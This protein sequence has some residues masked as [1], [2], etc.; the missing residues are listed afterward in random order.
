MNLSNYEETLLQAWEE[1]HKKGQLTLWIFLALK[2]GAKHMA[3]IKEFIGRLTDQ[4][5]TA[6]DKSMYRALR[7]FEEADVLGH[8]HI[9]SKNGPDLKVYHLTQTGDKIMQAFIR[10]HINLYYRADVAKLIDQVS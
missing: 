9:P 7:R 2:D 8:N 5:I 1:V 6:D 3:D 4:A 10:K